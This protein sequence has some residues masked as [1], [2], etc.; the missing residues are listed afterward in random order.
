[1][2]AE[3][4][5]LAPPLDAA[6]TGRRLLV[7]WQQPESRCYEAVGVLGVLPGT[8][9]FRYLP[10]AAAVPGFTPLPGFPDV[11]R[12]YESGR[13]FPLF[14]QRVMSSRR[15]DYP[16][17]L[18]A[19]GL[20]LSVS[21]WDILARSQGHRV[22]DS[23]RVFPEP[24]VDDS[25]RSRAS[26]FVHGLRY[27]LQED[28]RVAVTLSDL[29]VDDVLQLAPEPGNPV[30]PQAV[31]VAGS[32]VPLGW[33]PDVLADYVQTLLGSGTPTALVAHVNG[34]DVPPNLRLL[35]EVVGSVPLGHRPFGALVERTDA[36][37]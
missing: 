1:M 6:T 32:G 29:R 5:L 4:T 3:A 9:R 17:W 27:R 21:P 24:E 18:E 19:L 31:H 36:M 26:F 35:V 37:R 14:A 8:F 15:P 2:G 22:G 25:G 34:A 11:G 16:E 28:P 13:L 12:S 7:A 20:P 23:I 10:R 33:V 30:N